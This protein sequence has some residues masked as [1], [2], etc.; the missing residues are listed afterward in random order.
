M[1][2]KGKMMYV[3]TRLICLSFTLF[4]MSAFAIG[5]NEYYFYDDINDQ[6]MCVGNV[7]QNCINVICLTSDRIDCQE[8]C[9][10]MALRKC[11]VTGTIQTNRVLLIDRQ[12]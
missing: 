8:E 12:F 6:V 11:Q 4:T 3:F 5:D 10:A 2:R 7:T 9:E 1:Y